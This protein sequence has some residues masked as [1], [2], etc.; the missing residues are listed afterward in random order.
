[1]RESRSIW[2][3][4]GVYAYHRETQM[5]DRSRIQPYSGAPFYWQYRGKP[6]LLVGGS[7]EDNLYQIPDL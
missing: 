1:M 3:V 4:I 7:V 5:L 6:V 2:G